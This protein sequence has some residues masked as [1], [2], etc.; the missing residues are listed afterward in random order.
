MKPDVLFPPA[1]Q[2][3]QKPLPCSDLTPAR[4]RALD[5]LAAFA[6]VA[7]SLIGSIPAP[8]AD[9]PPLPYPATSRGFALHCFAA[10][11]FVSEVA[12][13]LAAAKLNTAAGDHVDTP[14]VMV[15]DVRKYWGTL[16]PIRGD[17]VL[18]ADGS[19]SVVTKAL[20]MGC[21]NF[22]GVSLA[23]DAAPQIVKGV[24]WSSTLKWII[25]LVDESDAPAPAPVP[26]AATPA[27]VI[28]PAEATPAPAAATPAPD[29]APAADAATDAT[30]KKAKKTGIG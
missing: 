28:A 1:P 29:A 25:R 14:H 6:A 17:I 26:A 19:A 16:G 24:H 3:N 21:Q 13:L 5:R 8:A 4:L 9:N 15:I 10:S 22:E 2:F 7:E 18:F 11:P 27:P 12:A 20:C 23:V 30:T